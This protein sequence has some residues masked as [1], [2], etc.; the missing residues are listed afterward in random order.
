MNEPRLIC[1]L[2]FDTDTNEIIVHAPDGTEK[3]LQISDNEAAHLDAEAV[4]YALFHE[5]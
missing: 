5:F 2:L 1:T 3:R 4:W